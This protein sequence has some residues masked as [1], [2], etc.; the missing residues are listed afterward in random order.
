MSAA[1]NREVRRVNQKLFPSEQ[2]LAELAEQKYGS[3]SGVGW[4]PRM[5]RR[6]GYVTPDDVY[7]AMIAKLVT[8]GTIWLD[9]GSG[10]DIFPSNAQTARIL[11]QRCKLLA[12]VDPSENIADNELLEERHTCPVEDLNTATRFDL[13]SMRMVAEHIEAPAKLAAKLAE[14]SNPGALLVVYTPHKWSL[15]SLLA[16]IV[17][18]SLHHGIKRLFWNTDERDTFPVSYLLN[19][20]TALRRSLEPAGFREEYFCHLDDCTALSRWPALYRVELST[21]RALRAIGL[22][23]PETC[24][25]GVYRKSG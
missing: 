13:I 3:G 21:R 12:G 7:E 16:R 4:R 20:R 6:L 23:Y 2:E 5:R 22:R 9:V 25:L 8:S 18:F 19:T 15:I 24:L 14:V 1:Q 17:P 11:A 10:R